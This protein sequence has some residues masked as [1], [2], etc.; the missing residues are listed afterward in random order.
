MVAD[1]NDQIQRAREFARWSL[2]AILLYFAEAAYRK[3][4]RY[5]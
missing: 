1:L 4:K 5:R 3:E 2:P